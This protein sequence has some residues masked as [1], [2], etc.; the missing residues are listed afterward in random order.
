MGHRLA[1]C[2]WNAVIPKRR[3]AASSQPCRPRRHP[4]RGLLALI[5]RDAFPGR[6]NVRVV[7]EAAEVGPGIQG[8]PV[9][10]TRRCRRLACEPLA[11]V[12]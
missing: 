2:G 12:E 1:G 8:H 9:T 11:H 4:R 6:M 5:V 10:V 7:T 3:K